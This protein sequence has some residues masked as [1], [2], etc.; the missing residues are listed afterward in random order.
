[1]I[2]VI[3]SSGA[4]YGFPPLVQSIFGVLNLFVGDLSFVRPE[5]SGIVGFNA[6][7]LVNVLCTFP[8]LCRLPHGCEITHAPG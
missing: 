1:M 3:T 6:T 8:S 4:T 5:C 2:W 7:Y